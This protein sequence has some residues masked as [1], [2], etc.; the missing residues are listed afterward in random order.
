MQ[1]IKQIGEYKVKE[2]FN[3]NGKIK[4]NTKI[5]GNKSLCKYFGNEV[6]KNYI[7]G[8]ML[9]VAHACNEEM[10]LEIVNNVRINCPN[11]DIYL[12]NIGPVI[13]THVGPGTVAVAFSEIK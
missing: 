7:G 12:C 11:L 10:A 9:I 2:V 5:R 8:G 3:E 6:A 1:T 4:L 13:G